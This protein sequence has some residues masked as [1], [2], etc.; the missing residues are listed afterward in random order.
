MKLTKIEPK[1]VKYKVETPEN[2]KVVIDTDW[3]MADGFSYLCDDIYNV[4]GVHDFC[5]D[6]KILSPLLV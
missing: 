2:I 6:A 3:W 5:I 4:S 1:L